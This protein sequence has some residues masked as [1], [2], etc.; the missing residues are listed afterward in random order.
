MDGSFAPVRNADKR[1]EALLYSE[2]A[3]AGVEALLEASGGGGGLLSSTTVVLRWYSSYKNA[4]YR[5]RLI[6]G[7]RH[8][9]R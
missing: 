6:N 5:S 4:L 9:T 8:Q 1:S 2:E 7:S 3:S